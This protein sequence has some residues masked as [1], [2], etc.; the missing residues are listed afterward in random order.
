MQFSGMGGQLGL[1][2]LERKKIIR[3]TTEIKNFLNNVAMG[4]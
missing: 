2:W 1:F 4:T 3:K